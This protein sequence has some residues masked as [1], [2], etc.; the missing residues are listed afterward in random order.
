MALA[1]CLELW[2][3]V[4]QPAAEHTRHAA[5]ADACQFLVPLPTHALRHVHS[6]HTLATQTHTLCLPSALLRH[7]QHAHQQRTQQVHG[8]APL[9]PT[10]ERQQLLAD[11][12]V[13]PTCCCRCMWRCL[14]YQLADS[15]LSLCCCRCM[16]YGL[17][18]YEDADEYFRSKKGSVAAK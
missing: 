15:E 12:E 14:C 9:L 8:A 4:L 10:D 18:S 17:L 11:S 1:G 16:M 13:S 7:S 3:A 5:L 6:S 2:S